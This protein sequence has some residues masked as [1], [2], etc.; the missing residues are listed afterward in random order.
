[1]T[2]KVFPVVGCVF[3]ITAGCWTG[4]EAQSAGLE[5]VATTQLITGGLELPTSLACA[6]GDPTRLFVTELPGRVRIVKDGQLLPKAFLDITSQVNSTPPERGCAGVTFH[7]DYQ[8]NGFFYLT[9]TSVEGT[10][11]L[12]RATVTSDPEVADPDSLTV[13]LNVPHPDAPHNIGWVGFGPDGFLYV[14]LGDGGLADL[15]EPAQDIESPLGKI[16]RIDVDR[17]QP[18]GI[19]S[20]NPFVDAPGRDEIWALGLRN[21]WR[22]SFDRLTGDLWIADVGAAWREEVNV[23]PAGGPGGANY[24]WNLFE[25]DLCH[26]P[27]DP[28]CADLKAIPP[29]HVYD[30][31]TGCAVI[32]GYVYRGLA[33]SPLTGQYVFGD[34]CGGKVWALDPVGGGRVAL[35]GATTIYSFGEDLQGELYV[36]TVNHL[37]KIVP[38]D[39]NANQVPDFSD[40]ADG[41]STD[42]NS[43]GAPDECDDG[44]DCNRN[45][46]LDGCDIASGASLDVDGNGIPD[47][48][49]GADLDG[50]GSVGHDDFLILMKHWGRCP[51]PCPPACLGDLDGDCDVGILDWLILLNSWG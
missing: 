39:C 5:H 4:A 41:T 40:I 3:G 16:L 10:C 46:V 15:G 48:C 7:P 13:L 32:G 43:N 25:G 42:C 22:C 14:G 19:P 29:L 18:Y 1:M 38:A 35:T 49:S 47:E 37:H 34:L 33:L 17:G 36:L 24:G 12:A 28:G 27:P 11:V 51:Q 31:A 20:G 23:Q 2:M 45:G 30:H 9:Y 50:D 26:L 44:D 6:P 8:S 21:P